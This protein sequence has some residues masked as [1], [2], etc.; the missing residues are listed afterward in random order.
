MND[1]FMVGSTGG[2]YPQITQISAEFFEQVICAN[3]R[4]LRMR[5][6]RVRAV[7]HAALCVNHSFAKRRVIVRVFRE[8]GASRFGFHAGGCVSH[9]GRAHR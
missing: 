9:D 7:P 6:Q 1:T 5:L 3:L 4:N 8:M 2:F